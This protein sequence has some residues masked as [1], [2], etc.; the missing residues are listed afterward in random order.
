[1]KQDNAQTDHYLS[2][3]A[4]FGKEISR[5]E[6]SWLGDLRRKALERFADLKFPTTRD[7]EWK[8]TSVAPIAGTPFRVAASHRP[9][10]IS[11]R[12]L[13]HALFG[14]LECTLLVFVNGHHA[15][16]LSHGRPLPDGVKAGSLAEFLEREPGLVEPHL[17]QH[18]RFEDQA[19]TA[20]NTAFLKDGAFI[21][22]PRM[23]VL[24]EPIHLLFVTTGNGA[25]PVSHPRNLI[26]VEEGSQATVVENYVT[27]LGGAYFTNAVTEV[28]AGASSVVDHCKLQREGEEAC[29]VSTL[30]S[31]L[32]RS[33]RFTSHAI[34]LGGALVRNDVNSVLDAEGAECVLN[35]LYL[36]VGCQHMDSHTLIDHARPNGTSREFYKGVLAGAS[37]GVFNGKIMV[38]KDAQK[39]DAR[40]T[41]KNLLL[42]EAAMVDTKPQLEI[43]AD[44]VK[45]THGAT[46]GRLDEDALF[47]LRSRGIGENKARSLLVHAFASDIVERIPVG[48][49]RT[50]L[51]CELV[52]RL[53]LGIESRGNP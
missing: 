20:L 47:Y 10:G 27:L 28:V 37:H 8:Y 45:C 42:S 7:E 38:R 13:E 51:E 14:G 50:G 15:P 19:F 43:H 22:V 16:E 46:I 36:A 17:A 4:R 40:Q 30:Q 1:M 35:G 5:K 25:L 23:K 11:R 48:P 29:H 52:T 3:F 32:G 49:I 26:V 12:D 39:T 6:P 44:D 9:N 21:H 53:P 24:S 33:S 18:A 2:E 31:H 41:N 34:T